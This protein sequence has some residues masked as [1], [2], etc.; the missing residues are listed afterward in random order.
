MADGLEVNAIR[1]A[2]H[3]WNA[4]TVALPPAVVS[5]T[6]TTPAACAGV[7]NVT[8]A[9]LVPV[10]VAAFPPITTVA[11]VRLVPVTVTDCAPVVGPR[12]GLIPAMVGA[13]AAL[14]S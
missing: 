1:G 10:T 2:G 13:A 7:V 3:T 5:V 6:F 12:F 4:V 14:G 9:A 8:A 11:P